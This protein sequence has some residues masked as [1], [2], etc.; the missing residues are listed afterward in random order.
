VFEL[1]VAIGVARA[2]VGLAIDLTEYSSFLLRSVATVL[3]DTTWPSASS[4]SASL[5]GLFDAHF[6]GLIGCPACRCRSE[7]SRASLAERFRAAA[8]A[9]HSASR[10]TALVE[11]VLPR[12]M[13]EPASRDLAHD[14]QR[15]VAG[16][17][18]LV[19]SKMPL[20]G[21]SSL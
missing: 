21:S 8:L 11:V 1:R 10:Q 16:R 18:H 14:F 20:P 5:A 15:A 9:T 17:P 19:G 4:A 12:L 2:F 3:A 13:A 6:K 7:T